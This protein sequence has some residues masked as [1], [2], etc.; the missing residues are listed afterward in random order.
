MLLPSPLLEANSTFLSRYIVP[1]SRM[2]SVIGKAGS[3]IKEIQE[4]SGAKLQASE[5]MLTGSTEVGSSKQ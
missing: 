4:A 3:K 2:G 1:N 5:A